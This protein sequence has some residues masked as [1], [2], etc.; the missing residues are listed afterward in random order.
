VASKPDS[1]VCPPCEVSKLRPSGRDS[2]HCESCGGQMGGA[3]LEALRQIT[4]LPNALGV[5]ACECG[6]PE[7]RLL[8]DGTY[9]CPSCSSEI[10]PFD[11]LQLLGTATLTARTA[12]EVGY[13]RRFRHRHADP[14][15]LGLET[16][17][18][19]DLHPAPV[20]LEPAGQGHGGTVG[21]NTLGC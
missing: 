11:A 21:K 6:H 16:V 18:T 10:L 20:G 14:V 2:M 5:H 1:L 19:Y 3:M 8:P 13:L 7:M 4:A 17:A 15:Y 9:H 12:D